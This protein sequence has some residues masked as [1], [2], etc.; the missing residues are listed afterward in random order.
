MCPFIDIDDCRPNH[1]QNG[2]TCMDKVNGYECSC[3]R[4]FEDQNCTTGNI[5]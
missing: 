1:C 2:G 3:A 4:G 5:T